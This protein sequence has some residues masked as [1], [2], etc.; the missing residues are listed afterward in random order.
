MQKI[1][2]FLWFDKEARQ[3]A[4]FYKNCFGEVEIT[5]SY[6]ISDTPSGEVEIISL[7]IF[8]FQFQF[9]SAGPDF[10]LNPSIS[11]HVVCKTPDE[12]D[13]IWNRISVGG[14]ALMELGSY[15]FSPRYGWIEDRF[16][17]SWQ[18]ICNKE[19]NSKQRVT[20]IIM[21]VGEVCGKTEEAVTHYTSI[22]KDSSVG[23]FFRYTEGESPDKVGSVKYVPFELEHI[24][25]GAMD[26]AHEHAFNFSEATSFLVNCEDQAE[27]DYFWDKLSA[28]PS[29]EQCGWLKD[30]YGVSWQI[31][32]ADIE[33]YFNGP[34]EQLA[35]LY[36]V[37]FEMKK[38][39]ILELDKAYNS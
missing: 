7:S 19:H 5:S 16:G 20:P 1:I 35:K 23:S 13:T 6:T 4:E 33:K 29:A 11:Y 25:F 38:I 24:A 34:R 14:K 8:D 21:F 17:V 32:P 10:K 3:A 28:D 31:A 39:D 37:L 27:I 30:R 18:I 22:F 36:K 2:P 12:V 15:P 26:S 9:M